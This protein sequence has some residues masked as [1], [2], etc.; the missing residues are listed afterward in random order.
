VIGGGF[1]YRDKTYRSLSEVARLITGTRW[2]GPLFFGLKNASLKGE[3]SVGRR[4][5][6]K[7]AVDLNGESEVTYGL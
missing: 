7:F 1:V 5:N 3:G 6:P 4:P 2:S